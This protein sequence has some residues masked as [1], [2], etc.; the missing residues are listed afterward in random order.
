[1]QLCIINSSVHICFLNFTGNV[2]PCEK[3]N[4]GCSHSCHP[5]PGGGLECACDD[6]S[7]LKIGNDGKICVAKSNNCSSSEFVCRN[8]R[9]LIHRWVCDMDDDCQDASDED[10]NMCGT[11]RPVSKS[12]V[13]ESAVLELAVSQL[14]VSE[15]AVLELAVS[16]LAVSESAVSYTILHCIRICFVF[17]VG[18]DCDEFCNVFCGKKR[19]YF[20][21]L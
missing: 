21:V 6:D 7:D 11:C 2:N 14:A 13:S 19:H 16:Q 1:M 9:C 4:G 5:A 3:F 12:A 15:S 8:G 20:T 18:I 17:C 10:P